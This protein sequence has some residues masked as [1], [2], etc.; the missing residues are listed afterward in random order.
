MEFYNHLEKN[1][2]LYLKTL[3]VDEKRQQGI[4]YTDLELT[5]RITERVLDNISFD[6]IDDV[7]FLEP[8]VGSGNFVIS[9]IKN[10]TL[11]YKLDSNEIKKIIKNIYVCDSDKSAVD[12]FIKNLKYFTKSEYDINLNNNDFPNIGG[13][14]I[15]NLKSRDDNYIG[16][17]KYFG[18]IKFDVI[19]T[20]PPYKGLRA[21]RRHYKSDDEYFKNRNYYNSIK[22]KS[23]Y[24]HPLSGELNANIYR[25]FVE[26]IYTKYSK[27]NS[28]ISILVP[29]SIL[30]DK[31]CY[32]LRNKIIDFNIIDI[33]QIPENNK[34]VDGSQALTNII[35]NKNKMNDNINVEK[36][37]NE[38][39]ENF[40][41]S[42][43]NL[44]DK[45][46]NNSILVMSSE[47]YKLL[48]KLQ[49]IQTVK[50]YKFIVN[51]RGELDITNNKSSIT[52]KKTNFPLVKGRDISRYSEVKY[53]N[54]T[55]YVTDEF[56]K[57]SPKKGFITKSRLACQ[58]IVNMKKQTR[59]GFTLV[60]ENTVLANSCNFIFIKNNDFGIDEYYAL[61]ILN[62]IYCDWY[63]KIFSSNNHVNNYEV[64]LLPFPI[65][66]SAQIQQISALAKEQIL[67][68]SNLRDNKIN[69]II[70]EIIDNAHGVENKTNLNPTWIDDL[71]KK[72]LKDKN[73]ILSM[74]GTLNDKQYSLSELD[75]E[76]IKSVP[77][78]GNWKNIPEKIIKK[79]K[80]LMKI[81]ETGGRTTLYGRLDYTKPSYTITTYFN[82][83]GNGCYIHPTQ[84]RVLTTREGARIQCFP[85]DYYFYGNQRDILNQIGN[86]VPPLIGYL[87]AKKIKE[88]INVKKSLDLFS[89]AGG[90]LYGFKMAGVEHV[91]ANDIDISACVTLKINNPQ[92]NI[93][94]DDVTNDY[95]KQIIISTAIQNGV[96]IICG[97]PP[98]Q[99]FSLA[100]LRKND[101]PRNKLVLDFADIIKSVEPKVFV[102]E[103]VIGLLSYNK[104]ETF[105]ELKKIFLS[106]GYKLHAETLDFSDYGVPQRRRRVIIVGVRNDMN[107][108]PLKLFP[109][110]ITKNKKISVME[111]IGD[112]DVNINPDE[113]NS[114]FI[115]LMKN[116]ISYDYYVESIKE[117]GKNV[118]E[119]QL[120]IF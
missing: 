95:T 69:K 107:V 24:L 78:G 76:I 34:Y 98:C 33:I 70:R 110:Q 105:S 2:D 84:D 8:C 28:V 114:K 83:P 103:N 64:D 53:E 50:D 90:L 10:A 113:K 54:I 119:E 7:K 27:P 91:L 100:G 56:V 68:H 31:S 15:Y 13:G 17:D 101:D 55:N 30:T 97:G 58:Q 48:N 26:E 92:V 4:Y 14:L 118:T 82:R 96:D 40:V 23:K 74:K 116:K 1:T 104:G 80:R 66:N 37:K 87:I 5:D 85:D 35:T 109:D 89:G 20:N 86:A 36:L 112:L 22:E 71:V 39:F 60:K 99:G 9:Y 115:S 57:K 32:D 49:S 18:D 73:E 29:S 75:L 12:L 120:C 79:S 51:M 44:V 108:E 42:K 11:K 21:E 6:E 81:R 41:I 77:Q 25:Y 102:F 62:S 47:D 38:K 65:G 106:L 93:F 94:C 63:F 67:E 52:T 59:I 61:A 88:N 43:E 111:A 72:G 45:S 19:I 16:I 3:E 117:N 46:H